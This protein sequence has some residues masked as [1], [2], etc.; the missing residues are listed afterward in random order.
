MSH[1]VAG[2]NIHL[3]TKYPDRLQI[4]PCLLGIPLLFKKLQILS[5]SLLLKQSAMTYSSSS[6][7]DQYSIPLC[8]YPGTEVSS[9]DHFFYFILH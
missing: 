9:F 7:I 5:A 3:H 4:S 2:Q 8:E 6:I 1:I